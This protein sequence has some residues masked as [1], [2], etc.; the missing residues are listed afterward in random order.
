MLNSMEKKVNGFTN[1]NDDIN[2]YKNNIF[3]KKIILKFIN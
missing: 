1:I 3:K 2:E